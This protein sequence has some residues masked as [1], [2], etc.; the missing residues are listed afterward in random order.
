MS[1]YVK[2]HLGPKL[3]ERKLQQES[4]LSVSTNIPSKGSHNP[5]V[6]SS[7]EDDSEVPDE[8]NTGDSNKVLNSFKAQNIHH[9]A[10][11]NRTNYKKHKETQG[12]FNP[13]ADKPSKHF[14]KPRNYITNKSHKGTPKK[15]IDFT[16]Y[17]NSKK[18]QT[19]P[20]KL[21]KSAGQKL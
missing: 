3:E 2:H 12:L 11:G 16:T 13:S 15:F 7:K 6:F 10:F 9:S 20:H 4:M 14:G 18:K 5:G 17:L 1:S 8:R 21:S 19:A